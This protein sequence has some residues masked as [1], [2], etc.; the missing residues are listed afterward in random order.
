M[1]LRGSAFSRGGNVPIGKTR[2]ATCPV[3]GPSVYP[4]GTRHTACARCLLYCMHTQSA[5]AQTEIPH[6]RGNNAGRDP[7]WQNASGQQRMV[8]RVRQRR[9]SVVRLFPIG[10]PP[11]KAQTPTGVS[12]RPSCRIVGL[13]PLRFPRYGTHK[14]CCR[15]CRPVFHRTRHGSGRCRQGRSPRPRPP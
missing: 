6:D 1:L 11:R 3:S 14:S 8:R 15:P 2:T 7:R 4:P 5:T 13:F 10:C 9:A 12:L